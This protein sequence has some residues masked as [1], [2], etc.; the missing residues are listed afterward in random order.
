MQPIAAPATA[1]PLARR[2]FLTRSGLA[3]GVGGALLAAPGIVS[4]QGGPTV[5][6][7]CSSGFPKA[8]D[9]IYGAAED[10]GMRVSEA[11]GG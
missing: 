6:W 2:S 5:R 3:A 11:T 7:R 1:T 8:L 10:V 9:T 4:A